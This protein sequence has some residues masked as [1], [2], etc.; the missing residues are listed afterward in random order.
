[1]TDNYLKLAMAN[2]DRLYANLP[3]DLE[4]SLPAEKDGQTYSFRSYSAKRVSLRRKASPW[5]VSNH[6]A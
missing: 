1:M 3:G 4:K 6:P 5:T 2:L